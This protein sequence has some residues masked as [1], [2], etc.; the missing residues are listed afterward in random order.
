ML[1]ATRFVLIILGVLFSLLIVWG[2]AR[3]AKAWYLVGLVGLAAASGAWILAD[4]Q[5]QGWGSEAVFPAVG[6]MTGFAVLG[7]YLLLSARKELSFEELVA[8]SALDT[9]AFLRLVA[10]VFASTLA[11][12]GALIPSIVYLK[13][14]ALEAMDYILLTVASLL[15]AVGGS[16]AAYK[17]LMRDIEECRM[18]VRKSRVESQT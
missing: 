16:F 8:C 11:V 13:R 3:K 2:I 9:R 14:L 15:L 18:R 10:A 12:G 6:S 17:L 5:R 7:V 4:L 1:S